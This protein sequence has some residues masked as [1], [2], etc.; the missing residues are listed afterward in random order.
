MNHKEPSRREKLVLRTIMSRGKTI[1]EDDYHMMHQ[2]LD[3]SGR[4]L[5]FEYELKPWQD[6]DGRFKSDYGAVVYSPLLHQI[7]DSLVEQRAVV[8]CP[9][10][11]IKIRYNW[12]RKN[13]HRN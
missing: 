11:P 7:I 9:S 8:R 5:G 6:V 2:I 12:C 3:L 10:N 13:E 1:R 4:G